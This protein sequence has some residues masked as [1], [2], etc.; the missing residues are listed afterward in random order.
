MK[1]TSCR[2]QFQPTTTRSHY[3]N[4]LFLVAWAFS[5]FCG[6][7]AVTPFRAA[8]ITWVGGLGSGGNGTYEETNNWSPMN[9]PGAGDRAL[10]NDNF[11]F[12]PYAVGLE[13]S[14]QTVGDV[15]FSGSNFSVNWKAES[16]TWTVLNSF[17]LDQGGVGQL[18]GALMR[19]GIIAVTNSAGTAVCKVGNYTDSGSGTLT[20]QAL[21]NGIGPLITNYPTLIA[22]SFQVTSNSIFVISAGTLTTFGGS[23]DYGTAPNNSFQP[24]LTNSVTWN[25]LGGTN[26]ITFT[27]G[28]TNE[29]AVFKDSTVNINVAGPSTLLNA[30][31]IL[32]DIG[33]SG[34]VNLVISNGAHVANT[35]TAS[36]SGFGLASSNDTAIV[37]GS[38]S[39]W[40]SAGELRVGNASKGNSLM[41]SAGAVVTCTGGRLGVGSS[42]SNNLVVVT[43]TNSLWKQSNFL[44]LGDQTNAFNTLIISNGAEVVNSG[45]FTRL[46]LFPLSIKNTLIVDGPGS[47]LIFT[48]NNISVGNFGASNI[49]VVK[50]GGLVNG[51]G[52]NVGAGLASTNNTI[53]VTDTNSLWIANGLVQVGIK[54]S[55]NLVTVSNA[56]VFVMYTGLELS[57]SVNPGATVVVSGG[58]LTATNAANDGYIRVGFNNLQG[59]VTLNSGTINVD[60]L[61]LT[62][63]TASAFN[64]NGGVLNVTSSQVAN[65]TAFVVGNGSS[66]AALN[67]LG[68][69]HSYANGLTISS[70]AV[71]SGIGTINANATFAYGS[72]WAPGFNG[73]AGTQTVVGAVVL[74]PGTILDFQLG[75]PAGPNDLI[76]ITGNLTLAGTVNVSSLGGFTNG[77]YTLLTYTGTFVNNT[78]NVGTLPASFSATVSN[79][80]VN[81][82]VLLNVTGGSPADPFAQWQIQYFGSTTN[83]HAQ[84][85]A[86]PLG[87]GIN[88]T[89]QF[90]L[91]LNPTNSASV[92][93]IVTEVRSGNNMIVTWR[94][95]GIRTNIL[96]AASGNAQGYTN[97]FADIAA[98]KTILPV[99]GDAI[100]NYVDVG[101]ATNVPSHFYRVRFVP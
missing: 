22:N 65:N 77:L 79:D 36:I 67:L 82:L 56:G 54:D 3:S 20:M 71:L 44:S 76:N 55:G 40:D 80:T 16:N 92:F 6:L 29:F 59:T 34:Y 75:P 61:L 53:L 42:S 57:P 26:T 93:R 46:G 9:I 63:G 84:P 78:L 10:F 58:T 33:W 89:N 31:G 85:L 28:G 52:V 41:I 60:L 35:G 86:D 7:L 81:K 18:A 43:G 74:N 97:N 95:A 5:V 90:L 21:A 47:A 1:Q 38:G 23:M 13:A 24:Q 19:N 2:S 48:N 94:A 70:N 96:Q 66:V 68:S 17:I 101:G 69:S 88:N 14:N 37:T 49:V 12:A 4:Q 50:N 73:I 8:D 62:N 15:L 100:T 32:F 91:G 64:F 99:I 98:S 27:S 30:G 39:R 87:K 72:A 11:E 25:V 51:G 45:T 83:S